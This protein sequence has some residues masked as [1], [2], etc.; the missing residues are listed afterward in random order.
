LDY[1]EA[2]VS[3]ADAQKQWTRSI[4]GTLVE[5][6]SLAGKTR[7]TK[8]AELDYRGAILDQ[9]D[10]HR[11]VNRLKKEGKTNTDEYRRAVIAMEKSDLSAADAAQAHAEAYV[12]QK[13]GVTELTGSNKK[14]AETLGKAE[15]SDGGDDPADA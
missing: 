12:K 11:E 14:F 2:T 7:N 10:A 6:D 1:T 4:S 8:E 5:L 3:A 9:A 15:E 13:Q